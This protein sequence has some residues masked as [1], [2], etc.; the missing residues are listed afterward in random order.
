MTSPH[1]GAD[2]PVALTFFPNFAAATKREERLIMQSLIDL[3]DRTTAAQKADLP[4]L[5]LARFGWT[6]TEANCLRHNDNVLTITGIEADYDG[7]T[8]GFDE[9]RETLVSAGVAAILYTS[10][11][12]T[13]DVPRWRVLAP[14]ASEHPKEHRDRFMDRLNGLFDGKLAG[15]SWTLSQSYYFGSV[16]RSPSH[17]ATLI[18]GRPIDLM[19]ELDATARGKPVKPVKAVKAA[20]GAEPPEEAIGAAAARVSI[21]DARLAGFIGSLLDNLRREAVDGQKHFALLRIATA[22]GGVQ[23]EAGF[24]DADA[25]AWLMECLP[26]NVDNWAGAEKT[27][28]DGLAYG[29]AKPIELE[30]RPPPDGGAVGAFGIFSQHAAPEGPEAASAP[31]QTGGVAAE[32]TAPSP[33]PA[34]P[35]PSPGRPSFVWAQPVDFFTDP[36]GE[37]PELRP[38]HIPEAI[39]GFVF[40][41]AERMGVDPTSVA[42]GC[43]V[44]LASIASDDWKVQPKRYDTTWTECARLWGAILGPPSV[45]KTPVINACTKPIDKFEAAARRRHEEAMRAY[46]L[47]LKA[48]QADKTGGTPEPKHPKR[49]RYLVESTTIEALSEILRE[50]DDAHQHA[51][52]GKIL[53]RHDEMSEFFANLDRYRAGGNGGGDRGAYLRLYNGGPYSVDRIGR[54]SF[55]SPN[56]SGGFLGGMQPGPIQNIARQAVEDG[57]LQRFLYAV[58]GPQG[59]G[60]DRKPSA[61]A[62]DRYNGLFPALAALRP[63]GTIASN[64]PQTAVFHAEAHQHREAVNR[65]AAVMAN[66]PDTTGQSRAAYGKW[67]G[68]FARIALSFHLIELADANAQGTPGPYP[69]VIPEQTAR[70]AAA[71]ML[72]IVLPHLL[73]AHRLMFSRRFRPATPS[74]NR[75]IHPRRAAGPDHQPRRGLRLPRA[76]KAP[77]ARRELEEVMESLVTI[78]WLEPEVPANKARRTFQSAWAVNPAVHVRFQRPRGPGTGP[79]GQANSDAAT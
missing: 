64:H 58:P 5:K 6:R 23:A 59:S 70:R 4:W 21:D 37:A 14:L 63:P 77:E 65:A 25:W 69:T 29:R 48:A 45:L 53:S 3:L 72:D 60:A 33:P 51:P 44:S 8:I 30:D 31:Q 7:G 16:N 19:D 74:G 15:E 20:N 22:L 41:T 75:R 32:A 73:R 52:A 13:E 39:G 47:E 68:M 26:D 76:L 62:M 1:I 46:K 66:M 24:T 2:T 34:T 28:L 67:A 71:F 55:T 35:P 40:D 42:L 57:L 11:S 12:H 17:R 10:P 36:D 38:E 56:W 61:A 18:P 78:G 9:A 50:D 43:V 54:G 27:A 49:D 79:T